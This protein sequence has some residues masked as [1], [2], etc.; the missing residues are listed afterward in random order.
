MQWPTTVMNR[1]PIRSALCTLWIGCASIS[2]SDECFL[3]IWLSCSARQFEIILEIL[4]E[5]LHLE[6]DTVTR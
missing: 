4:D 6:K 3:T 5:L 2:E 1:L